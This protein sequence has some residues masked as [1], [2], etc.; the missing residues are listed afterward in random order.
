MAT[1]DDNVARICRGGDH[2]YGVASFALAQLA[3][4]CE[5]EGLT[6]E[7]AGKIGH[8]LARTFGV[9][10]DEVGILRVQRGHL[11]FCYPIR[12]HSVGSIP[13]STIGSVAVR[14]ANTR[15]PE[16][17]NNFVKVKHS[18]VFE[19]VELSG[20]KPDPPAVHGHP[21][22]HHHTN[23]IQK[24]M[25]APMIGPEGTLGV[26][27]I[28]RKGISARRRSGLHL[29]RPAKAGRLRFRIGKVL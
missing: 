21:P 25:A 14:T 8:E 19:A 26:I 11:V 15:H 22:D 2:E 5:A 1:L 16:F 18:S 17:F 24:L 23:V 9:Q 3:T 27:E 29:C 28:S 6:P 13:L 7:N 12:L 20:N 10:H 4:E